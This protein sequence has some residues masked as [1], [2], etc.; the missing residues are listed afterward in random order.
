M[1]CPKC[2]E[3]MEEVHAAYQDYAHR[4]TSCHG[5]FISRSAMSAISRE[6]FA[7]PDLRSEQYVDTGSA[8]QGRE[9]DAVDDIECP[10][11]SVPMAHVTVDRQRHIWL[12]QCD[13]CGGIFFDAGE[14]T[15]VRYRTFRDWIRDKLKRRRPGNKPIRLPDTPE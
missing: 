13:E 5:L 1:Q 4:C 15:D 9:Y 2:H 7:F 12:E 14:L 6:W 10:A 8:A 3:M 11:C